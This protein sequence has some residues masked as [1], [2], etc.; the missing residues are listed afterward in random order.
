MGIW[1]TARFYEKKNCPENEPKM[2]F[3]EFMKK[4]SY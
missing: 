3:V 2:G 1:V 4:L